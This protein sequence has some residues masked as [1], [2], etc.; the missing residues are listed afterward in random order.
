MGDSNKCFKCGK[1]GHWARACHLKKRELPNYVP[2]KQ[3]IKNKVTRCYVCRKLGHLAR[4][5]PTGGKYYDLDRP[6]EGN[7]RSQETPPP[8]NLGIDNPY[9]EMDGI[10]LT[11]AFDS[12]EERDWEFI[13]LESQK[14][15]AEMK[16]QI[17][18]EPKSERF[19]QGTE[20]PKYYKTVM[21]SNTKFNGYLDTCS[22]KCLIKYSA[23]KKAQ[24]NVQLD[25]TDVMAHSPTFK[26]K[27]VSIGKA[28]TAVTVDTVEVN[29]V[30]MFVVS[31]D[32]LNIDVII[33]R[34]WLDH[35]HIL[36]LKMETAVYLANITMHPFDKFRSILNSLDIKPPNRKSMTDTQLDV[37]SSSD[38]DGMGKSKHGKA[39]KKRHYSRIK[40]DYKSIEEPVP[41]KQ[42]RE[43]SYERDRGRELIRGRSR[44]R[45]RVRE[46]RMIKMNERTRRS[47][48]RSHE[49]T[50]MGRHT[51]RR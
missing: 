44:S 41:R 14:D 7:R 32:V 51:G 40:G 3:D 6:S 46:D 18:I 21:L 5:C 48:E 31:D 13:K 39:S 33:G 34:S 27:I 10:A 29:N 23:A 12:I 20:E 4:E 35:P 9:G 47:R 36:F 25:D 37:V 2:D 15:N 19:I 50:Y 16:R 8:P 45:E 17:G 22:E 49:R 26:G 38:D 28:V 24:L 1:S 43:V 42:S 11:Q 30:E